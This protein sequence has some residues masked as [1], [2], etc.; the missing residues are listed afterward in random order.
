MPAQ[1]DRPSRER[2]SAGKP[3]NARPRD[4]LGRP[5]PRGAVGVDRIPDDLRLPPDEAITRAQ[6]LLD[7]G[8]PFHAHEILEGTWKDAPEAERMLW[9]GL[10]QLAVGLTHLL[11]GNAV[12]ARSLLGQ[13]HDRIRDHEADPPYGLDIAGLLHWS[14]TLVDALEAGR[15]PDSPAVPQLRR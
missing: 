1:N 11:R 13:G 8:M 7:G 6:E 4:G 10:A 9:Q 5:L 3:Q 14:D 2:D 15:V 12:G